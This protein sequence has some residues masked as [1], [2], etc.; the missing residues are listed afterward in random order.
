MTHTIIASIAGAFTLVGFGIIG[1][2]FRDLERALN[3]HH[4]D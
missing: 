2:C 1:W 3:E 4:E